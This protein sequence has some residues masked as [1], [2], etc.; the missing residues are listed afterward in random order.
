M[1]KTSIAPSVRPPPHV[2][3]GV[4]FALGRLPKQVMARER[5]QAPQ[6]APKRRLLDRERRLALRAP[7]ALVGIGEQ[8]LAHF[9]EKR[10]AIAAILVGD[11]HIRKMV[12]A[13]GD[14]LLMAGTA[15]QTVE[16]RFI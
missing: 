5:Q 1:E 3:F 14:V 15:Q 7:Y 13:H 16:W 8:S 10:S 4:D 11:R 6:H 2:G 9:V 12:C